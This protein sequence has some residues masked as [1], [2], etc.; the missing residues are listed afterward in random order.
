MV[1]EEVGAALEE[2][3]RGEEAGEGVEGAFGGHAGRCDWEWCGR[4]GRVRC[5][6]SARLRLGYV[7][8][9]Q[10]AGAFS[11]L[12][13]VSRLSVVRSRFSSIFLSVD[14]SFGDGI[15]CG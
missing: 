8:L 2:E 13:L 10:Q 1:D 5:W 9:A 12:E 7:Q 15:G 3:E 14:A 4:Y 6:W 11:F